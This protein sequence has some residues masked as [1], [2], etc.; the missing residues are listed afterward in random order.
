MALALQ[1][2]IG[3]RTLR[4]KS[5]TRLQSSLEVRIP[6][7]LQSK[8]VIIKTCLG[9]I[10]TIIP[11]IACLPAA[12]SAQVEERQLVCFDYV[13]AYTGRF[14]IGSGNRSPNAGEMS[15]GIPDTCGGMASS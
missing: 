2:V 5:A 9:F 11:V 14:P 1:R 10:I 13:V 7:S 4:K 6:I 12:R 8:H 15:T 3:F